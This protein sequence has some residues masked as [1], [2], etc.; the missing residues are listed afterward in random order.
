M[1]AKLGYAVTV[2]GNGR[3]A[4]DALEREAVDLVLMDC[5]M[6]V[7]DGFEAVAAI[8]EQ[9]RHRGD[10]RSM[11]VIALTANALAGDR[12]NCIAAGMTDYLSKPVTQARLME[13]LES[14]LASSDDGPASG[15][16]APA[17]A[18]GDPSAE[19]EATMVDARPV[20]EPVAQAA[21]DAAQDHTDSDTP[22]AAINLAIFDTFRELDPAGGDDLAREVFGLF[23]DGAPQQMAQA[24]S[25]LAA[26]DAA[27]LA[28]VAHG[29]KS[30]T[31]N[32]GADTLASLWREVEAIVR[33]G[34][35]IGVDVL[36]ARLEQEHARVVAAL[37]TFRWE[38]A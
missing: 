7:M 11:P 25:A 36:F 16:D 19:A 26:Q 21:A 15:T 27:A 28:R 8:R 33:E 29:F 2:V 6:P 1:L 10:G 34:G 13:V 4:L 22:E 37:N 12:D 17:D 18:D 3:E 24:R 38:Q 5:Q 31:A 30:S 32:I 9:E 23:L 14:H 20:G 35:L